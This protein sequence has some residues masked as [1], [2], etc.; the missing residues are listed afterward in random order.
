MAD[1]GW[2]TDLAPA[3]AV[4]TR[5]L[6]T[7]VGLWSTRGAA[8]VTAPLGANRRSRLLAA[9]RGVTPAPRRF[10]FL[11]T[12]LEAATPKARAAALNGR[13]ATGHAVLS[14]LL[15]N[16]RAGP[17]VVPAAWDY[18]VARGA[19]PRQRDAAG[20]S[21]LVQWMDARQWRAEMDFLVAHGL[22]VHA[23]TPFHD[24]TLLH[25]AENAE[26]VEWAVARGVDVNRRD[27]R[28]MTPLHSHAMADRGDVVAALAA[29]P[30]ADL[31]AYV[32]TIA[33]TRNCVGAAA[34]AGCVDG[35]RALFAHGAHPLH[36]SQYRNHLDGYSE[37][38]DA[39]CA[40]A[41]PFQLEVLA[42]NMQ[43]TVFFTQEGVFGDMAWWVDGRN[44]LF[45]ADVADVWM[46]AVLAYV[47]AHP[48]VAPLV[49]LM[50]REVL[51]VST[52]TPDD[53]AYF[54]GIVENDGAR[55]RV[56]RV[57]TLMQ[58]ALI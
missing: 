56:A 57:R 52:A 10:Y 31:D 53:P 7:D 21:L 44:P 46:P 14:L 58:E 6:A 41:R 11:M 54:G 20:F 50:L 15:G 49:T 30:G 23:T 18:A 51:S 38:L 45:A 43:F 35:L 25:V 37:W 36:C 22:S 33:H 12:A 32:D 47:A 29:V 34:A 19:N 5:A 8:L 24:A 39:Y 13:D 55:A 17:D 40:T 27:A 26:T 3:A 2:V 42:R 16:L 4:S 9:A 1:E 28:G 48:A